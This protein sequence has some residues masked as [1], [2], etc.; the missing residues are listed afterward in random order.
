VAAIAICYV[1][2]DERP[3]AGYSPLLAVLDGGLDGEDIHTI[4]LQPWDVLSALVVVR[5]RRRTVRRCAHA[6]FVV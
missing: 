6:I 1:L 5:E 4:D 2:V 3:F